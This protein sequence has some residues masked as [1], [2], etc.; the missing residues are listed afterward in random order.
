MNKTIFSMILSIFLLTTLLNAK[1]SEMTNEELMAQIMKNDQLEKDATA[2]TKAMKEK[3]K[4]LERLGKT[5]DNVLNTL[6][7]NK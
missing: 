6:G 2:K 7:E 3:T 5:L 4:A 1:N